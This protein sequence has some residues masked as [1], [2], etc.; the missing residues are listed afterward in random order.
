MLH[1]HNDETEYPTSDGQPMAETDLHRQ[2][3]VNLIEALTRYFRGRQVYVSGN[4]LLYYERG[5]PR[6]HL[7]PDVLVSLDLPP[8]PREIYKV[9]EEGKMPDLVIEVTS[10]STRKR[11]LQTKKDL[12]ESLGVQEYLLFDPRRDYLEP[13]F[14]VFR[15][16]GKGFVPVLVPEATG[17]T[18]PLLQL[19]FRVVADEL[20]ISESP[21]GA[22][23]LTPAEQALLAEEQAQRAEEQA[24]RAERY[25]A[26]LRE[27]GIEP[28]SV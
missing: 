7:A 12:Y 19:T 2:I 24:Q 23:L 18:S 15:R 3:M 5:N 14:Q 26:R 17:Y 28:D 1:L 25:A 20:R 10:K 21:E 27:L 16:Q 8:G 13:R 9:W 11:D 4:I 22:L 6:A